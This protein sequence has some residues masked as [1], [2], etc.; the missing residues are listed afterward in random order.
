VD[1][2]KERKESER[3]CAADSFIDDGCGGADR[4]LPA[5]S[6]LCWLAGPEVAGLLSNAP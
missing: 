2:A 1:I 5:G 6:C 4:G 3:R